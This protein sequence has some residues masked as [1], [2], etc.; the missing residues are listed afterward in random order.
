MDLTQQTTIKDG[1]FWGTLKDL[2]VWKAEEYLRKK[3]QG[4]EQKGNNPHMHYRGNNVC[5]VDNPHNY[6]HSNWTASQEE[7]S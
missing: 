2:G 5:S 7:I 1:K 4:S 3:T 6:A